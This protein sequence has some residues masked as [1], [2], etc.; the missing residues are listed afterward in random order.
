[1]ESRFIPPEAVNPKPFLLNPNPK[2]NPEE[3]RAG[4]TMPSFQYVHGLPEITRLVFRIE[5][6]GLGELKRD[7]GHEDRA[8]LLA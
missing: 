5:I 3:H 2:L 1:M 6:F 4:V 7:C 8:T